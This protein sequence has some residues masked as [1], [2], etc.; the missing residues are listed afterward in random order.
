M[1]R[2]ANFNQNRKF[3]PSQNISF[4]NNSNQILTI[5]NIVNIAKGKIQ[6]QIVIKKR[7][8][9]YQSRRSKNKT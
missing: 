9:T 3:N 8:R 5:R 2:K 1:M 6:N 4:L 7:L